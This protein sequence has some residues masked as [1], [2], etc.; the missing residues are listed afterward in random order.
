MI[1]IGICD[2]VVEQLK[3][4]N[5]MVQNITCRM[6]LNV[7]TVCFQSGEDLLW[8]IEER[9][10][11]DIIFMDIEMSRMNGIETARV[12]R[13][14]DNRVILIF[15]S[16]YDQ[17]CKEMIN[18]QPFAFLDK[19]VNEKE[20]EM[21]LKRAFKV[22][23][24]KEEVFEYTYKKVS[25]KILMRRIRLFES[26]KRMI[27]IHS[28]DGVNS[29]YKKLDEVEKQLQQANIKFLRINKSYLVNMN[30]VKEYRYEKIIMDD[31]LSVIQI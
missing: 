18:V 4:Q 11:L 19:P 17:Y 28:T 26:D 29:F 9:G 3:M 2:D 13:E 8:E 12:I 15:I 27:N 22:L 6:S 7:E 23:G 10:C 14:N 5:G 31:G 25:Y 24:E 20:M 1:R 30:Y 21:V 16:C